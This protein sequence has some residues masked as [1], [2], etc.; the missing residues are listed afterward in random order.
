MPLINGCKYSC[1]P[2][3]RGHRATSCA[4]TDRILIEVRKPG[5]PLESCGHNLSTCNCGRVAEIFAVNNVLSDPSPSPFGTDSNSNF[6]ITT[7]PTPSMSYTS[8][9]KPKARSKSQSGVSKRSKKKTNTPPTSPLDRG[10]PETTSSSTGAVHLQQEAQIM[11]SS[12]VM[13]DQDFALSISGQPNTY[14]QPLQYMEHSSQPY[15]PVPPLQG[16]YMNY[17]SG[18]EYTGPGGHQILYEQPQQPVGYSSRIE[19]VTIG[20]NPHLVQQEAAQPGIRSQYILA[21]QDSVW[22]AMR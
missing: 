14:S 7:S 12:N 4:H 8:S 13:Q 5:R 9:S 20:Q 19:D 15:Q 2:C 1:E 21:T 3:I 18:Q 16:N 17:P 10:S 6:V 11:T 22:R